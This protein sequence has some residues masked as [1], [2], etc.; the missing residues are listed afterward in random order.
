[1]VFPS[2]VN[3]KF[4]KWKEQVLNETLLDFTFNKENFIPFGFYFN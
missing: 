4:Y 3:N 2:R 1:M